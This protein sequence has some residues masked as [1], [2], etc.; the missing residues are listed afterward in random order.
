MTDEWVEVP[1]NALSEDTLAGVIEEFI[2]REGTDYGEQ[3]ISLKIK[4]QQ[5]LQMLKRGEASVIF[6]AKTQ[7]CTIVSKG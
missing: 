6:D 7:S 2:T 1:Y 3:E 5:I 4:S